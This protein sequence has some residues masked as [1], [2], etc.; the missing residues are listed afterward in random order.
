MVFNTSEG[1][2]PPILVGIEL[3]YFEYGYLIEWHATF[4]IGNW[5]AIPTVKFFQS[6]SLGLWHLA[7]KP[8]GLFLLFCTRSN[9][10]A[11][12]WQ[13]NSPAGPTGQH[14]SSSS[15]KQPSLSDFVSTFSSSFSASQQ[16]SF[17]YF[18][19]ALIKVIFIY[20]LILFIIWFILKILYL[21]Y[22]PI[23]SSPIGHRQLRLRWSLRRPGFGRLR[24]RRIGLW[25]I[26]LWRTWRLRVISTD[27]LS[28]K[29]YLKLISK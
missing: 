16:C 1:W 18:N 27:F 9:L 22:R 28:L 17:D 12:L 15:S 2:T 24:I 13:I 11:T 14:Q 3:I 26:R 19:M 25:R 23:R 5:L 10:M 29:K 4:V 21:G 8:L 7:W 20:F 6:E